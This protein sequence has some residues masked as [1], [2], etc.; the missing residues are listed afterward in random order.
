MIE[1]IRN[2]GGARKIF[3]HND[4]AHL[5]HLLAE[6]DP[7]APKLVA[8][9][10][11]YSMDGDISP[12]AA[13]SATGEEVRRHDL[14]RRSPRG[15]PLRPHGGGVSERDGIAPRSTSSRARWPRRSA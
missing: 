3:R 4:L 13:R 8:F 5:E 10:S 6:A 14:Y 7:A 9:E 2:G 1:G 15:R 11:V 12:S